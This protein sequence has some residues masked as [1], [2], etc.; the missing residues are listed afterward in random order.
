M[1][2]PFVIVAVAVMLFLN[3]VWVA[4]DQDRSDAAGFTGYTPAQVHA[5]TGS[6]LSDLVFGP[7]NFDFQINGAPV[8]EPR[9]RNHMIDVRSVLLTL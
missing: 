7:P 1:A 9:E 3:P 2:T 6:I 8:L 4:F 5:A